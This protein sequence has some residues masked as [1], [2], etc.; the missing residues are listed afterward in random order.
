MK[1]HVKISLLIFFISICL[2]RALA[3]AQEIIINKTDL[4]ININAVKDYSRIGLQEYDWILHKNELQK[5]EAKNAYIYILKPSDQ[6]FEKAI[7]LVF[8]SLKTDKNFSVVKEKPYAYVSFTLNQHSY[9]YINDRGYIWD[10][11]QER[12]KEL[13]G[14][15]WTGR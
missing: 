12:L 3:Y 7:I 9:L 15:N 4:K 8:F 13:A 11:I 5:Y 1:K 10:S 14:E 2:P 6:K